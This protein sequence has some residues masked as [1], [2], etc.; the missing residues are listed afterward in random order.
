MEISSETLKFS[1]FP[2]KIKCMNVSHTCSVKTP[3]RGDSR[4]T[5]RRWHAVRGQQGGAS[6][7]PVVS[8]NNGEEVTAFRGKRRD[9]VVEV[10]GGAHDR[11]E[12]T[13]LSHLW[14]ETST[15]SVCHDIQHG[16]LA[17][18][19]VELS[20]T[21]VKL[22]FCKSKKLPDLPFMVSSCTCS[23]QMFWELEN[24]LQ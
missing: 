15:Q 24:I 10:R 13:L 5:C 12:Q 19:L 9:L 17:L 22:T 3:L 7:A 14:K 23:R 11:R 2:E 20:S 21:H 1:L 18:Q 8:A 4:P 16:T 6:S